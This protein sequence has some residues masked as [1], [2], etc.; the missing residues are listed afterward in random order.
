MS[1]LGLVE[2]RSVRSGREKRVEKRTPVKLKGKIFLP[3]RSI[4]DSC[5]I[6]DFSAEGAGIKCSA[7]A[8]VGK[9]IVLY[10]DC[11]GRFDGVVVQRNRT[12]LGIKFQSS[13][14][15]KK[16]TAEQVAAYVS[17]GMTSHVPIRNSLRA[18]E[19]PP[20]H[21]FTGLDGFE[22]DCEILD[23]ALGGAL[24]RTAARPQIGETVHFGET[25]GRVVRHTSEGIAIEFG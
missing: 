2:I 5:E 21:Q 4:E 8:P 1:K 9:T 23:I 6:L 20:L 10:A 24:L 18:K 12:R 11:F 22:I 7:F 19:L 13:A 3:E 14:S 16:R 17:N 25:A 15:K